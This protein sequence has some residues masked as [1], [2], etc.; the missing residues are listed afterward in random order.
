MKIINN[1]HN[2]YDTHGSTLR[3]CVCFYPYAEI[4]G[5][6]QLK[7]QITNWVL[8]VGLAWSHLGKT[9]VDKMVGVGQEENREDKWPC[10]LMCRL[11]H[12]IQKQAILKFQLL[13][14]S[15]S[16]WHNCPHAI[17]WQGN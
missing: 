17:P 8:A 12:T 2:I 4:E 13:L 7:T 6:Q 5:S 9:K 15:R 1:I 14:I 10:L 3:K 16:V 11:F